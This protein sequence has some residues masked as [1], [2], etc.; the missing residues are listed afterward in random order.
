MLFLEPAWSTPAAHTLSFPTGTQPR[1][2]EIGEQEYA[3]MLTYHKRR[4][5]V[6]IRNA[7]KIKGPT[8]LFQVYVVIQHL[9][10]YFNKQKKYRILIHV[11]GSPCKLPNLRKNVTEKHFN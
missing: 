6:C 1:S 11:S 5:G 9:Y 10:N 4:I 3:I 8:Q 2:A 7:S